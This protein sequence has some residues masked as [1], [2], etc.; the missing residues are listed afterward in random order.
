MILGIEKGA[1]SQNSV[2]QGALALDLVEKG[3]DDGN[4][5]G[6]YDKVA[7]H[8]PAGISSKMLFRDVAYCM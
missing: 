7:K 3:T 1:S 4:A 6:R 8:L 5:Y 2:C